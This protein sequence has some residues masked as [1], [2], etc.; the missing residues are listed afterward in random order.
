MFL[1]SSGNILVQVKIWACF[2]PVAMGL[3]VGLGTF[4]GVSGVP[5]GGAIAYLLI[6]VPSVIVSYTRMMGKMRGQNIPIR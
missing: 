3:K 6:M 4:I 2:L 1:N 5:L